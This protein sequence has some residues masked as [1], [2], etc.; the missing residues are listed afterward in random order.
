MA[1]ES[2]QADDR[3][4][5]AID[6]CEEFMAECGVDIKGKSDI[7]ALYLTLAEVIVELRKLGAESHG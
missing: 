5:T 3:V 4:K 2:M 7:R 1:S 6:V